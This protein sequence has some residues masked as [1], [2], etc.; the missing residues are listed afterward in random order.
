M[1]LTSTVADL[2]GDGETLLLELEGATRV[3]P[4][5]LFV[6]GEDTGTVLTERPERVLLLCDWLSAVEIAATVKNVDL[7]RRRMPVGANESTFDCVVMHVHELIERLLR[8]EVTS[9]L[10]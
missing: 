3:V 10:R 6:P 8:V 9:K 2:A 5:C 1:G 4:A 7:C